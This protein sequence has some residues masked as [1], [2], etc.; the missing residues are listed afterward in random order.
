MGN[1]SPISPRRV[2]GS[3]THSK[4]RGCADLAG[5]TGITCATANPLS[6]AVLLKHDICFLELPSYDAILGAVEKWRTTRYEKIYLIGGW[7]SHLRTIFSHSVF[8]SDDDSMFGLLFFVTL[9]LI[10][11]FFSN[12]TSNN[13]CNVFYCDWFLCEKDRS[14]YTN[15]WEIVLGQSNAHI[16]TSTFTYLL[17][18]S[19]FYNVRYKS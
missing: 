12:W 8:S 4:K 6:V 5:H 11:S 13:G 18:T 14:R 9:T 16:F 10:G 15:I 19:L 7:A 17:Q 3:S 1:Q 2:R